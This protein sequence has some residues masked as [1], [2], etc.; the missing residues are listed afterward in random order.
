MLIPKK[1]K[2]VGKCAKVGSSIV[3]YSASCCCNRI[4]EAIKY[5]EKKIIVAIDP[6][7]V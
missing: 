1:V 4:L 6:L 3:Y 2:N 5:K 7:H